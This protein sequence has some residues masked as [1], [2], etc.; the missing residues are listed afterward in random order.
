M[1]NKIIQIS[2]VGRFINYNCCGDVELPRVALIHAE[3]GQGKTT[4][5]AILRSLGA[6]DP[7]YILE[8]R[9]IGQQGAPLVKLR[10]DSQ[11]VEFLKGS[12]RPNF[13]KHNI[14]IFDPVFVR[15]NVYSGDAVEHEQKKNLHGFVIGEEGV[16]LASEID[17]LDEEIRITHST[18]NSKKLE[19]SKHIKDGMDADTFLGLQSIDKVDTFISVKEKEIDTLRRAEA[20]KR[21]P[22]LS[23]L[24]LPDLDIQKIRDLLSKGLQNIA[25]DAEQSVKSHVSTCMDNHGENWLNQGTRYIR[26]DKCPFCGQSIQ[27]VR[28]IEAYKSFFSTEYASFKGEI[29]KAVTLL[30]TTLSQDKILEL[31]QVVNLNKEHSEFWRD[32]L[33]EVLQEISFDSLKASWD[34]VFR[35]LLDHLSK[36][37]SSPL[38]ILDFSEE[39]C[40]AAISFDELRSSVASFNSFVEEVNKKIAAKKDEISSTDINSALGELKKLQN[41]KVRFSEPASSLCSAYSAEIEK[42]KTQDKNKDDAKKKLR[43]Y[44]N[45]LISQYQNQINHYLGLFGAGFR[46]IEVG[47]NYVGGKPRLGYKISINNIPIEL[48]SSVS[49]GPCFGNTLSSGDRSTLAFAFF[50]ARLDLDTSL[51]DK[52]VVFDDPITSLDT[53]RRTCTQQQLLRI[54]GAA[55]QVLVFSHDPYFLRLFWNSLDKST[56]STL[57]I[58]REGRGSTICE[59][60]IERETQGDYFKNYFALAEYL[61]NGPNGNLR[62][63]ARC[64]RPLLEGNLR[65]RFPDQFRGCSGFGAMIGEIRKAGNTDPIFRLKPHL[66]EL[67]DINDYSKNFHHE[68]NPTADTYPITDGEL[69][70]FVERTLKAIGIVFGF[71]NSSLEIP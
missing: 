63:V 21:R 41:I 37:S 61:A 7:N 58:K 32:L 43:D 45:Q 18:L 68:E 15:Q 65:L 5:S 64:I 30:K 69:K 53:P 14:I 22:G 44:S 28:L 33:G 27:S 36:K 4:I 48:D 31:Q 51:K 55:Q 71:D 12:W 20:I 56:V 11:V 24:D 50:L 6:A 13:D 2:N 54:A 23:K 62:D 52:V 67:T 49:T 57:C 47:E 17:K 3:N 8:R 1:I 19:L 26:D 25:L 39:L 34:S 60:D 66:Q 35:L 46:I 40:Q 59:W 9:S 10:I 29:S 38:E 70:P 16:K 42:K